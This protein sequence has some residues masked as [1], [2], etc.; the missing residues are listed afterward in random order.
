GDAGPVAPAPRLRRRDAAARP[1]RGPDP[2]GPRR[3]DRGLVANTADTASLRSHAG[4][5][6]RPGPP[7]RALAPLLRPAAP[8]VHRPARTGQPALQHARCATRRRAAR[9]R[10]AGP[11][12]GGDR[13]PE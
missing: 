13:A 10:R 12:P 6:A 4:S 2:G 9:R 1:L 5:A 3:P 11:L 7:G 8:L